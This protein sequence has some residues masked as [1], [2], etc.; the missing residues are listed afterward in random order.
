MTNR[1]QPIPAK[2]ASCPIEGKILQFYEGQFEAVFVILHP[3]LR[4]KYLDMGRFCPEKW[5]TKQE[6]IDDCSAI[7]WREILKL[8]ELTSLADIDI[9]LRTTIGGIKKE[10]S[11]QESANKLNLL[12]EELKIIVPT[13]GDLPPLLENRLFNAIKKLGHDWLWV[14]DEFA[15]ERK[16]Y[17]IDD[18]I[19]EDEVPS[20][21]CVFTHDHSLLITTH[22]DSHCSLLCSSRKLIENIISSDQFE[23]FYCTP[24][25][26]VYWGVHEI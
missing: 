14:G 5:P 21:G 16:L 8:T 7:T 18:L 17:L 3:F 25:T 26:E 22:W 15:T 6:I 2:F 20:H 24:K 19:K 13:E 4:P 12:S 23:G 11:N 9:G 10:Y 1:K